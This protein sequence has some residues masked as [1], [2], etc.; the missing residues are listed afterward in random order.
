MGS[1]RQGVRQSLTLAALS[2]AIPCRFLCNFMPVVTGVVS[3][4]ALPIMPTVLCLTPGF[5]RNE[6]HLGAIRVQ[7]LLKRRLSR[8]LPS[9]VA[10]VSALVVDYV[11]PAYAEE[12]AGLSSQFDRCVYCAPPRDGEKYGIR[13]PT[14]EG[15]VGVAEPMQADYI[16]RI[17][18]DTFVWEPS[19]FANDIASILKSPPP[20]EWIAAAVERQRTSD[21]PY[22]DEYR[23]LCKAMNLEVSAEI[24]FPQ[25]AVMLSPTD[26]WRKYYLGLTKEMQHFFEDVL[27]GQRFL[28][29]GGCF[30]AMRP[31]WRHYHNCSL[32]LSECVFDEQARELSGT[33]EEQHPQATAIGS[34]SSPSISII[35]PTYNSKTLQTLDRAIASVLHQTFS[36]WELLAIDD[37]STDG[38]LEALEEWAKTDDRIRVVQTPENG[39]EFAARNLG[40]RLARG[41]MVCYLDHDDEFY[42]DY[43]ATIE[44]WKNE[45]DVLFFRYD[46]VNDDVAGSEIKTY[47]PDAHFRNMFAYNIAVP[48]G[49]AHRRKWFERIGGFHE[50][51]WH[52]GD[53]DYWKRLA[54]AG[55]ETLFVPTRSGLYH[56]RSQSHSRI[57]QPSAGQQKALEANWKAGKPLFGDPIHPTLRRKIEKIAFISPH[58]VLD[59]TNGAAVATYAGLRTVAKQGLSCRAICGSRMDS[60]EGQIVEEVFTRQGIGF[61]VI[62]VRIG[63]QQAR[64]VCAKPD[65]FPVTV[66]KNAS[67]RGE[68]SDLDTAAFLTYCEHI[69]QKDRPDVVWT[70]G[71]DPVSLA[72]HRLAKRM[73]I[74]VVFALHNFSYPSAEVFRNVDY[75]VVPT[76]Y[77]RQY[78]WKR[79]GLACQIL[80]NVVNWDAAYVERRD[81]R[82][83]TF[84]NP[85]PH[86]GVYIFAR[87][88]QE[89][90]R[91]R[92][93][94]SFLVTQGRS[95]D[96]SLSAPELELVPLASGRL[97]PDGTVMPIQPVA[98][99][100]SGRN[101]TIMPYTP[102][103]R[104][105]YPRVYSATKMLLMPSLWEEAFGLVAAE[106]MLNGIPVLASTRGALPDTLGKSGF[107]FDIPGQYTPETRTVPAA[108]EV[109]PWVRTII[110]LWD[111]A[112]LFERA[113]QSARQEAHRW[114]PD[115]LAPVYRAFFNSIC[116]QPGPPIL[117]SPQP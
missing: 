104:Q 102:D 114:H 18:Q 43:L 20:A 97:R 109:E 66:F 91:R 6:R 1:Q 54:R 29:H 9:N 92:P 61:E 60:W 36:D 85:L 107:V 76:E 7:S 99:G 42:P 117:P 40:L 112:A 11:A 103:P 110:R 63:R 72:V 49:V 34:S 80:P 69:F 113:S 86:K 25:G 14:T 24:V 84:I 3:C 71:G 75:V 57:G 15:I 4:H 22:W 46:L 33:A 79:L 88:A 21:H 87:I 12:L 47:R 26:V 77:S 101:L 37:C 8:H 116:H 106:A 52:Q 39:R 10:I 96:T 2:I 70:Y 30:A 67:T 5:V 50:L 82:Y 73:D 98:E 105:F 28:R 93:D 48:L 58:C 16:L 68:W 35:L 41:E 31:R 13:R 62:D 115:Q 44:R 59:F 95:S 64:V 65:G 51:Q 32:A 100:Q 27:L 78:Y 74:P 38:T 94:I 83:V 56:I 81:P 23:S 89:L 19:A 45:G 55:A 17:T 108:V 53:W 111:D 90:A